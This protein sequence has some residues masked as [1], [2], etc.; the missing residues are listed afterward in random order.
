MANIPID[1]IDHYYG[2][3]SAYVSSI[4]SMFHGLANTSALDMFVHSAGG[5]HAW[6]ISIPKFNIYMLVSV[7]GSLHLQSFGTAQYLERSSNLPL[8]GRLPR[9]CDLRCLRLVRQNLAPNLLPSTIAA[10]MVQMVQL[11]D[12]AVYHWV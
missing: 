1:N 7:P 12:I 5:V 10:A 2:A 11:G 3:M 8:Q 4:P 9:S 6:E